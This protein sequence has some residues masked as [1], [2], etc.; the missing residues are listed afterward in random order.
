MF[1]IT[2]NF[3]DEV[4]IDV[5]PLDIC[6]IVLGSPYL[7]D[8]RAIFHRHE[9]KYH[10]FKNGV[11]YIV[12]AHTKKMNL[13]LVNAGQMKR[14]VNASKNFVLLMIKPK[15]NVEKET[16]EG[17]D[18]KLKSDLYEVVNQYDE[19]FQ[20]PKG[21]PP[22]R[23]IQHEI[24]LQQDCPP[25]NIG[26]YKMSVMENVQ[27]KK[28]IQELLGKGVIMPNTSPCGSP[29]VLVPKK[30]GPWRMCVDFRALNKITVNNHYPLPRI[31]DLL[32]QLRG[33][34]YFT[35]LDLRSGYHQ[36]M[37]VEGD[38]WKTTFKTKQGLLEWIVIPFG[39]CNA[40]ATFMRVMTFS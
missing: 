34:K 30:D 7:Y 27:I 32:D 28:Q 39:L 26:M 35:K 14:L 24:R 6:G 18:A 12:R 17:C 10:L 21:L 40:L 1:A 19:M 4:E 31:D 23:G 5:I 22:K 36:I 16:F 11:E 29:I 20:K 25:P 3:R 2:A 9:N 37:I 33:A 8:R 13:S 15:V 38:T